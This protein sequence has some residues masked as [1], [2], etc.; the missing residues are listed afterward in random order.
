M[1]RFVFKI[2]CYYNTT[3]LFLRLHGTNLFGWEL[4]IEDISIHLKR[5]SDFASVFYD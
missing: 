1:V 5:D 2:R 4:L 3:V